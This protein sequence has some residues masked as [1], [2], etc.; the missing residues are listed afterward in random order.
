MSWGLYYGVILIIEKYFLQKK[1]ERLPSVLR[2]IYSLVLVMIG[3]VLFFS[4]TLGSA[5]DYL[6]LMFGVGGH[7]LV[8]RQALYLLVSNLGLW[9]ILILASTPV[10]YVVYEKYLAHRK[11][12]ADVAVYAGLFLLCIAYLVTETYNP[13]L[14]FRF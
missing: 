3:W 5:W 12:A 10:V 8:D 6:G 1:L 11:A 7:G 9:I 4:P 13:F 14:Y 2:H